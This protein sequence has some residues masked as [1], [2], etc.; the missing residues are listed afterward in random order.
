MQGIPSKY[1]KEYFP[2]LPNST[3]ASPQGAVNNDVAF[4]IGSSTPLEELRLPVNPLLSVEQD[5]LLLQINSSGDLVVDDYIEV[6]TRPNAKS[7][8]VDPHFQS[9]SFRTLVH[10]AGIFNPSS[11]PVR[12]FWRTSLGHTIFDK[13]TFLAS[14]TYVAYATYIIPLY[15]FTGTTT[16]A[17]IVSN[18]LLIGSHSIIPLQ[19]TNSTMVSQATP[20]STENVVINQAPIRT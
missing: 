17:V 14:Q 8:V 12:P 9:E 20:V 4:E 16:D 2:L 1:L 18:Q 7:S 15:H 11:V 10:T 5:P 6:H 19:I 3:E 13:L